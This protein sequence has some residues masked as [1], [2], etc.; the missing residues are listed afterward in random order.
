MTAATTMTLQEGVVCQSGMPKIASA[1][2]TSQM[3]C[4]S[5]RPRQLYSCWHSSTQMP[6]ASGG[7]GPMLMSLGTGSLLLSDIVRH[8]A[9]EAWQSPRNKHYPGSP[10]YE[11]SCI[12]SPER[13]A[14][15]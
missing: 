8:A 9:Q 12:C 3:L 10:P 1:P 14:V 7:P 15:A 2:A 6:V 4:R 11:V 5:G 13:S